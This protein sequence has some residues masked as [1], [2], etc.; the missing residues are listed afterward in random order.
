LLSGAA[1]VA[2]SK[3]SEV[4]NKFQWREV[5]QVLYPYDFRANTTDETDSE[6]E[7]AEDRQRPPADFVSVNTQRTF[8]S[9]LTEFSFIRALKQPYEDLTTSL[10]AS[11]SSIANASVTAGIEKLPGWAQKLIIKSD[12]DDE[13]PDYVVSPPRANLGENIRSGGDHDDEEKRPVE[14]SSSSRVFLW[15]TLCVGIPLLLTAGKSF[16]RGTVLLPAAAHPFNIFLI[17]LKKP[18][19]FLMGRSGSDQTLING[20]TMYPNCLSGWRVMR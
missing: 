2:D 14:V 12:D 18:L 9:T 16:R 15:V 13:M 17:F 10:S 4:E 19:W 5:Y 3:V 11:V 1:E 20:C 7:F 6:E 8:M